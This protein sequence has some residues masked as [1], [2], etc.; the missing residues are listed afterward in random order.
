MICLSDP[1]LKPFTHNPVN[2]RLSGKKRSRRISGSFAVWRWVRTRV[3]FR[4]ARSVIT[5]VVNMRKDAKNTYIGQSIRRIPKFPHPFEPVFQINSETNLIQCS[6]A[7][8]ESESKK[9]T[10]RHS[11]R[12]GSQ[13]YFQCLLRSNAAYA[14]AVPHGLK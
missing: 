1:I 14:L 10:L 11:Q 2:I 12:P 9:E 5:P 3:Q 6:P 4:A 7:P 8:T 13:S